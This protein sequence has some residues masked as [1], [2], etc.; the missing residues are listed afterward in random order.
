MSAMVYI[1]NPKMD[2]GIPSQYYYKTVLQGY[3]DCGLDVDVLNQAVIDSSQKFYSNEASDMKL[4]DR[5]SKSTN[6]NDS[7]DRKLRHEIV[8]KKLAHGLKL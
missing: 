7:I 8:Q 1:M 5:L 6:N 2:F 4:L 3:M